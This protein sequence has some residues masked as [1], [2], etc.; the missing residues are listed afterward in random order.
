MEPSLSAERFRIQASV[1]EA[2]IDEGGV[3]EFSFQS[4]SGSGRWIGDSISGDVRIDQAP[5][6]WLTARGTIP[7]D[8]FS[9]TASAKPVDVA[10]RSSTIQL[11]LLEGFT[12]AVRNVVGT[13]QLDMTVK[14]R[15]NDP[16]FDGF[17]DLQ[18]RLV[19][20]AR[21]RDADIG[22]AM[23]TS[24]LFPKR[25]AIDTL[26]PRGQQRQPGRPDR[27]GRNACAEARRSRLRSERHAF[28]G[29]AQRSRRRGTERRLHG[30]WHIGRHRSSP[31]TS[32]WSAPLS[33]P[34]HFCSPAVHVPTPVGSP[35][36]AD[37]TA[38]VRATRA[39]SAQRLGQPDAAPASADRPT[40]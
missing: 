29:A 25:C 26:P 18:G 14:G 38:G 31:A 8:L 35:E 10:V 21:D 4:I 2:R 6:I 32:P 36:S 11:A 9:A 24:R 3:R 34:A 28:R 1:R 7:L 22:T 40:T 17:V 39:G 16:T 23:R 19:R 20:C 30:D 27:N 15:A 12:T 5:G 33:T 13:A 37:S